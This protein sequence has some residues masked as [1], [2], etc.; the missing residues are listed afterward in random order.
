LRG[1]GEVNRP[2]YSIIVRT[3]MVVS[4]ALDGFK[5]SE[6]PAR[7]VL[8]FLPCSSTRF[9]LQLPQEDSNI[10]PLDQDH[11]ALTKKCTPSLVEPFIGLSLETVPA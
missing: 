11:C 2:Y 10:E 7:G 4:I 5:G 9:V 6:P 3:G 1:S 8:R